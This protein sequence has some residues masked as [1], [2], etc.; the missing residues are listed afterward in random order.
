[1]KNRLTYTVILLLLLAASCTN[2]T[3]ESSDFGPVPISFGSDVASET[4]L[5]RAGGSCK[6]E[7]VADCFVVTGY[8]NGTN[9]L[10]DVMTNYNVR[11]VTG[12]AG[13][14][15][16]NTSGWEYVGQ[17]TDQVVKYWDYSATDYRFV[18]YVSESGL[19]MEKVNNSIQ[20][21]IAGLPLIEVA[22]NG[23]MSLTDGTAVSES[24]LPMVSRLWKG[25]PLKEEPVRLEFIKPYA[26]LCIEIVRSDDFAPQNITDIKLTG[27]DGEI[28]NTLV[29]NYPLTGNGGIGY[30]SGT[31]VTDALSYADVDASELTNAGVSCPVYPQ[32]LLCPDPENTSDYVFTLTCNEETKRC[33]IPAAKMK[34]EPGYS[35]RFIFKLSPESPETRT[36]GAASDFKLELVS[37][38]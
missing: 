25:T 36:A 1:M 26:K 35:Y 27:L 15:V 14:S 7:D 31:Y 32:Y 6:L 24:D 34:L 29:M 4:V 22:E 16:T 17:G 13:S 9:G 3:A 12:K 33:T 20:L 2:D 21:T 18:A 8:K 30:T 23:N 28:P 37:V 10:E 5:T 11:Y 38:D 19:T